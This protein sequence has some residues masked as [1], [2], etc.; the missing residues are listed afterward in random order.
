MLTIMDGQ[1]CYCT[2]IDSR[3]SYR[4]AYAVNTL[5]PTF[6]KPGAPCE[7]RTKIAARVSFNTHW[8]IN[9]PD[10]QAKLNT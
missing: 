7:N 9:M 3:F 5:E 1:L 10:A 4:T 6:H 8:F 2:A